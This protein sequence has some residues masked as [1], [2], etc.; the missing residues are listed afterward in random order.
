M[1]RG[2]S[3]IRALARLRGAIINTTYAE[4]FVLIRELR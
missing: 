3:A 4:A 1:P 2:P